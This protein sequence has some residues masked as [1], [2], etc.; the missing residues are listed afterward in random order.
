ML[1]IAWIPFISVTT[2]VY[3]RRFSM[4]EA[5]KSLIKMF[6]WHFTSLIFFYKFTLRNGNKAF[7]LG[8][9]HWKASHM[10]TL[11]AL[12]KGK[13]ALSCTLLIFT[14]NHC[15]DNCIKVTG[16]F[17]C[18]KKI[19]SW[20]V[21]AIWVLI[22]SGDQYEPKYLLSIHSDLNFSLKSSGEPDN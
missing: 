21:V 11:T 15:I 16:N 14:I 7:I 12:I 19:K 3:I 18:V 20:S 10:D 4:V 6:S 9:D 8:F 1:G 17:S 5:P 22:G 2:C 13:F